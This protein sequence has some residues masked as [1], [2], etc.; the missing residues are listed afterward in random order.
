MPQKSRGFGG[1][2]PSSLHT[3]EFK[4][5]FLNLH[6]NLL[7]T[8]ARSAERTAELNEKIDWTAA[9]RQMLLGLQ[10]G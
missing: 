5:D 8:V 7:K 2:P 1:W 9:L 10:F 3:G 6:L 4:N